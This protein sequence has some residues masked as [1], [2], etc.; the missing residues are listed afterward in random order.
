MANLIWKQLTGLAYTTRAPRWNKSTRTSVTCSGAKILPTVRAYSW[1]CMMVAFT[2]DTLFGRGRT[3]LESMAWWSA[4]GTYFVG[5]V[6][7][8]FGSNMTIEGLSSLSL[9]VDA[10]Y[11][12]KEK[13]K[14][15]FK[16]LLRNGIGG[17]NYLNGVVA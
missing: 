12:E 2:V 6:L 4:G 10:C 7:V 9:E 1:H 14:A 8:A 17:E 13:G 15:E 5:M 3:I 11:V 16:D